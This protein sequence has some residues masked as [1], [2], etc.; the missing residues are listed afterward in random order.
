MKKLIALTAIAAFAML[1]IRG[2][3][4]AADHAAVGS[5]KCAKMCHKVEFQSWSA[6]KHATAKERTECETCH[7]NGADY[8]KMTVMK[9]PAKAKEAGLIAKPDMA[10]CTAKCHKAA[11]IKPE[12]LA[13]VHDHKVKK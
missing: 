5:E 11:D 9:D 10:S 13:K 1:S 2:A 4:S 3:V 8:M 7:G 6:S 12:M